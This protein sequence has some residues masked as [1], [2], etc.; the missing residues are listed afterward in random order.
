MDRDLAGEAIA[1]IEYAAVM[2]IIYKR[3]SIFSRNG[4][5]T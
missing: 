1:M 3:F 2:L 4:R 5:A